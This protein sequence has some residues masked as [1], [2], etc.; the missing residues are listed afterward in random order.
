MRSN[1][2]A[3]ALQAQKVRYRSFPCPTKQKSEIDWT[4]ELGKLESHHAARII[5]VRPHKLANVLN[6]FRLIEHK[7]SGHLL[8]VILIGKFWCQKGAPK[9]CAKKNMESRLEG[10]V[11]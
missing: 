1:S 5:D 7:G 10:L 8:S 4:V 2:T 6:T 9:F 11:L 3:S